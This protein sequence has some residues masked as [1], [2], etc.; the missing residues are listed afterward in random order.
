ME[1]YDVYWFEEPLAIH[2]FKSHKTLNAGTRLTI[3]TGENY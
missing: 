2:D 3:A 1:N